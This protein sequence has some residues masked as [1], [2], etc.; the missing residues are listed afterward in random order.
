MNRWNERFQGEDYVFGTEPNVFIADMHKKL[1][2]TGD[3]LAIAEGEGRNA[4]FLAREGMNVTVWDYAESGLNKANQLAEACNVQIRTELVD[5]HEAQWKQ[6]QW[7][8]II[9][10]FGHFPKALR[11]RTLEGV[12]RAVKPGGYFLAE[13]YS[14]Y[15]IPYRSGGP[16]DQ[17]FLYAP[18]D[19]LETFAEWRI[20]HFFMGEV[21]RQEGQ[22]HQG[23]SHVIQ[24]AGQ[25]P[26]TTE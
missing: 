24:F 23:L 21:I 10:V 3:A 13:V 2:L 17:Q 4:V 5:L 15:Q 22:G 14:P 18:G 9:C 6:D 8:E 19:F 16:Q 1:A 11:T 25:K 26:R 20:V 12:K 7:D